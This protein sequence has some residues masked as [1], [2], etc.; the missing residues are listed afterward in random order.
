MA[1]R[2]SNNGVG[3]LDA[4]DTNDSPLLTLSEAAQ[5]LNV[6]ISTLR[7]WSNLGLIATYRIG[8]R[9]DR[10]FKIEDIQRI[11][12]RPLQPQSRRL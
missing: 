1:P 3:R 7:R 4:L 8:P 6:H 2:K 5:V 12:E 10:R 11:L 9:G